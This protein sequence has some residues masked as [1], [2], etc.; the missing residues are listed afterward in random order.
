MPQ[1][2][3]LGRFMLETEPG[4]FPLGRDSLLLGEFA[5]VRSGW[6]VWD[7]GCGG[8]VLLLLLAQRAERLG[9]TG[10]ELDP[11]AAELA[12]RNLR[13]NGLAGEIVAGDVTAL[14]LPPGAADLVV[15]NPPFFPA[16]AGRSGGPARSEETLTLTGLCTAAARLLRSGGRFALC[17]RPHRLTALLDEARR[18][19]LEPKRLQLVHHSTAHPPFLMLL[20]CVRGGRP[21]MELLPPEIMEGK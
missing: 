12:R 19:G 10:V 4:T 6:Q 16:D 18:A 11:A 1:R 3:N 2:E 15:S 8:G 17:G 14:P 9:L 21:G 7:L 5:T 13:D 20:E